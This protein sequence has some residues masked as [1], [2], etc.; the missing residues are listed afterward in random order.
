MKKVVLASLLSCSIAVG[1]APVRGGI[2][3]LAIQGEPRGLDPHVA[4]D[5]PSEL[6]AYLIH[7]N[8]LRVNRATQQVEPELATGWKAAADGR[9]LSLTLR[10]GLRYSDGTPFAAEDVCYSFARILDSKLNSPN[11]DA[12]RGAA[13]K[14]SC[15]AEAQRVT[16]QFEK[17]LS[18]AERWM[19]GI[20]ILSAKSPAK[21]KA[22]L[23]PFLLRNWQPGAL[24]LLERN[25]YYWK[26]DETGAPLPYLDGIRLEIQRNRDIEMI[27]FE[28][29]EL[30]MVNGLAPDLYERLKAQG[31]GRAIQ[32]GTSLDSE[33]LWFNQTP[34]AP[35]PAYKK[36][37][38]QSQAFRR[39]VSQAIRR[40]DLARVV[41]RGYATP[42]IG[43]VS[44]ANVQWA[45]QSLKPKPA[46]PKAGLALL[47]QTGFRLDGRTLRDGKGNAVEFTVITNAGSKNR[48]KMAALIQQDLAAIGV[49][50]KVVT[51]DFPSLIE[52]ITKSF[53]YEACLL[54]LVLSDLD[55]NSQMN[56][57]LSSAA[58]HQWNPNQASPNTPWEA[59]IDKLMMKQASETIYARRKKAWDRVQEIIV[60]Q[61][62]FIYL[63]HPMTLAAVSP[64]VG[65]VQ[66]VVLRPYLLW[67][68]DKLFVRTPSPVTSAK[69]AGRKP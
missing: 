3:R 2:L 4:V 55:P 39:A 14:V 27:R 35:M 66:P 68:A 60:E 56:V 13:G 47:E 40:D 59:E 17:P 64:N 62:P 38:F 46:D 69:G 9:A 1:A 52:R 33:Q 12:L 67:N 49:R 42:A 30:D 61:S 45:N 15:R 36:E 24:L 25:P 63:V 20:A 51:L 28:K 16:L 34:G 6:I 41:Y 5:Q 37:W 22:G 65:N 53:D 31:L 26:R 19:D 10:K 58:N 43:A 8:L 11:G 44:P 54:G 50:L 29:G 48:E 23:G 18:A 21:E 32:A 57:W 7:G